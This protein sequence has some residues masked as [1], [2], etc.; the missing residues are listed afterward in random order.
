MR[1]KWVCTLLKWIGWM[2]FEVLKGLECSG[3]VVLEFQKDHNHFFLLAWKNWLVWEMHYC[4]HQAPSFKKQTFLTYAFS[5][6]CLFFLG[7][8]NAVW[9]LK[10]CILSG[11]WVHS[12]C[13]IYGI[14]VQPEEQAPSVFPVE[15]SRGQCRMHFQPQGEEVTDRFSLDLNPVFLT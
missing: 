7:Q 11:V 8:C 4:I 2:D 13:L 3:G 12:L 6:W 10:M 15:S 9:C 5:K 14:L 1:L